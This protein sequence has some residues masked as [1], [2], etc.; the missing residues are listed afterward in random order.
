MKLTKVHI[1][2]FQSIQDSTEFDIDDVTCLVGK[3]ESGKTALLKA[4]YRLNP[5]NEE[6]GDF[7][8]I[9]DYP[10]RTLITYESAIETGEDPA[11]VVQAT[12]HKCRTQNPSIPLTFCFI[13][14]ILK[15]Y[16]VFSS[17]KTIKR[18]QQRMKIAQ[19]AGT[20]NSQNR[21]YYTSVGNF[22]A[23]REISEKTPLNPYMDWV[24]DRNQKITKKQ[25][26][27]PFGIFSVRLVSFLRQI[28]LQK[29][30]H[31]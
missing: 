5:I 6:D 11:E 25:K 31:R 8:A 24:H 28:P 3:N 7:T 20:I 26:K 10:R 16:Y 12:Y 30:C 14:V 4:L 17:R 27:I 13:Y 29:R 19:P 22:F 21:K 18:L 9:A 15:I 23:R 2:N 1:T